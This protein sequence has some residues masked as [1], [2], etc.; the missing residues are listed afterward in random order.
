MDTL[1]LHGLTVKTLIGVYEWERQH[2][3]D[4]LLDL[5]IGT[6][7]QLSAQSDNIDD[8]IHYGDLVQALR[9]AL[10]EQEFLLLETLA[11]YVAQFV[12]T[13]FQ[14]EWIKVKVVKPGILAGVSKVGIQ[15]ER[16]Q[17]ET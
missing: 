8:T 6:D 7:F 16:R 4:L 3:Q 11:E 10:A 1:F 17:T 2:S 9:E 15:I 5:D 12:L 14:A 13:Q